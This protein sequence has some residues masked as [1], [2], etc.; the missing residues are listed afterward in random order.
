MT[1]CILQKPKPMK[2]TGYAGRVTYLDIGKTMLVWAVW[3]LA[4]AVLQE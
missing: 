3:L 2:D 4:D 1:G